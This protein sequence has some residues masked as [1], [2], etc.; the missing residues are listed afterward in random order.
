VTRRLTLEPTP[1]AGV[2]VVRRHVVGD[3]RGSLERL[4]CRD[5]LTEALGTAAVV[6]A[7][8][9]WTARAGT[10]RGMHFQVPP[11]A[12]DKLVTCIGG[13]VWDVAVDLRPGSPTFLRWHAEVL[14]GDGHASLLIPKGCAHG[15]QALEDDCRMLY[16]HTAP[17]DAAAER[18]LDALDP[19]LG[20][21]W[22]RA[23]TCRSDRDGAHPPITDS[24]TGVTP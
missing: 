8:L 2:V 16:L 22:P 11:S 21:E 7:N 13:R 19:R 20:I 17:Y 15:F 23:V 4:Y 18:G 24:F 12:E 9:T 10:V 5:E 1:I 6:Q 3:A 14:A